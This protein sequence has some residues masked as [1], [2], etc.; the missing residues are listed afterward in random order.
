MTISYPTREGKVLPAREVR[1]VVAAAF[2]QNAHWQRLRDREY[3]GDPR[4]VRCAE[5]LE[6]V[7]DYVLSLPDTDERLRDLARFG[8]VGGF[9]FPSE[10]ASYYISRFRVSD[11]EESLETFLSRLLGILKAEVLETVADC[12]EWPAELEP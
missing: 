6:A 11:P 2:Y 7:A 3:P 5:G 10:Q 1:R 4:S 12:G 9:F 8:I